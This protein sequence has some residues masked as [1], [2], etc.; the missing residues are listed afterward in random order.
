MRSR[1]RSK[2]ELLSFHFRFACTLSV[3]IRQTIWPG[4]SIELCTAHRVS[5]EAQGHEREKLATLTFD[6]WAGCKSAG[7]WEVNWKEWKRF[8]EGGWSWLLTHSSLGQGWAWTEKRRK[9]VTQL[10]TL[11]PLLDRKYSLFSALR[12]I[13]V[14]GITCASS[15]LLATLIATAS[16][17]EAQLHQQVTLC[18][19]VS[20]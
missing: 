8:K 11:H 6:D 9:E 19:Q 5:R 20:S 13:S 3:K 16:S 14:C 7:E 4:A 17:P 12:G 10:M 18:Q 15:P 2:R 1:K